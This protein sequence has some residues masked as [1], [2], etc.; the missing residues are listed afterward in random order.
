MD[1][2]C[3]LETFFRHQVGMELFCSVYIFKQRLTR[4]YVKVRIRASTAICGLITV[5]YGC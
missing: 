3:K 2:I 1:D 4:I 5:M